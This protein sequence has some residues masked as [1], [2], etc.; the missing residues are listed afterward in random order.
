MNKSLIK[1]LV[2]LIFL[3]VITFAQDFDE[4]FLKSLPEDIK[5]DLLNQASE[6]ESLE[7]TQ[8][9]RPS[10]FILKPDPSSINRFGADIFSMMQ[11]TLMP[12]N[13]PNFDGKYI[14]DYGDVLELQLV[15]QKSSTSTLIIKRDGSV[16]IED[17]GKIFLSGLSLDKAV[18]LINSKVQLSYIGVDAY[19]TLVNVRDIQVI[20]AGNVYNP[21]PYTLNGNSNIFHA[22]SMAGGPSNLGSYRSIDLIRGDEI[23]ESIDLYQTFIYGKPSFNTRLRSGDLVFV[24]PVS[25]LVSVMGGVSRP[26]IYE[27][28]DEEKMSLIIFFANGL[29]GQAD[30]SDIQL[31]RLSDGTILKNRIYNLSDLENINPQDKDKLVVRKFLF[32]SVKVEG[33]V[34]NPGTYTINKDEGIRDLILRAGG[35]TDS[36]YPFGGVL[37]SEVALKINEMAM[38]ELYK[39]FLDNLSSMS[40]ASESSDNNEGLM[41]I[42][43]EMKNTPLSGRVN[44]EFDI[45]VLAKDPSKDILLQD[46]DSITIPEFSNQVYIFGEVS[47]EG[48]VRFEKDKDYAFYINKKGGYTDFAESK[49]IF[50]MHPNGETVRLGKKNIFMNNENSKQEIYPGSI[51]FVPREINDSALNTRTAQAYAAILGNIGVSL[52]SISV[53]NKD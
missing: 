17:I 23:I 37:E 27:L 33:A 52:A 28:K 48:T 36:A 25:N 13:E 21:G 51:I 50:I 34:V 38:N 22:L 3:P 31:F 11:T 29:S 10:T 15:G 4:S 5:T 32:K 47:T 20:V 18:D 1:S 2:L 49:S 7:E 44:A 8:Y 41:A 45:D 12:S 24:Q 9:R 30:V 14:L 39:A 16:N 35:Y 53:L 26:G 19:V 46:G 40:S 42:M 6:K 43:Q